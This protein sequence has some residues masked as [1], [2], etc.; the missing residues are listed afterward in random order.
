MWLGGFRQYMLCCC[1]AIVSNP[2]IHIA[3]LQ[4]DLFGWQ[5][6]WRFRN[7]TSYSAKDVEGAVLV[8]A[9]R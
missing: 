4:E 2:H 9:G 6:V 8:T 7:H 3:C 1:R 5:L